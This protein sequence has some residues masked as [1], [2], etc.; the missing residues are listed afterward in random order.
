SP[1]AAATGTA[2]YSARMSLTP[3]RNWAAA[4]PAGM[5]RTASTPKR[6]AT[7]AA[8]L[9]P[10]IRPA[11]CRRSDGT[12]DHSRDRD[13]RQ[14]V[15]ERLEQR[16]PLLPVGR[17][18][19]DRERAREPE[20]ERRAEGRERPPLA[21][22]ERGKA[23]EAVPLRHVLVERVVEARREVRAAERGDRAGRDDGDVARLVHGDADRLGRARMLADRAQAEPV[24]RTED[25]QV[26]PDQQRERQPDHQVELPEDRPDEVPVL[27][28][29]DV[30]VGNAVLVDV[31]GRPV[32]AV[33]L[34]EEVAGDAEREEVERGAGDDLVDLELDRPDGVDRREHGAGQHRDE[35]RD[36]P[37]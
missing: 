26:R 4:T 6:I 9:L 13:Q 32:V 31:A 17:G 7:R 35:Q 10:L 21:E 33:V 8:R 25:E 23:D 30:D 24:R 14:Q 15:R 20:E 36:D 28:E 22:D 34:D 16:P 29:V 1:S 2:T 5:A 3:A 27:D 19:P 11:R 18:Q 37:A 12:S